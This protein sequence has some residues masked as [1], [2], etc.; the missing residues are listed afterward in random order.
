MPRAAEDRTGKRY[1]RWKV[2]RRDGSCSKPRGVSLW[3]CRCE[4]GTVRVLRSDSLKTSKSCGCLQREVARKGAKDLYLRRRKFPSPTKT[5]G[6][7]GTK[8]YR[9]WHQMIQRCHNPKNPTYER[10]GAIGI[11]VCQQWRDSFAAF[12]ADMGPCPSAK[13]TIDRRRSEG[14]YEPGNCRWLPANQQSR[15]RRHVKLY[16]VNGEK[17][18]VGEIAALCGLKV[19]T[20]R[21]RFLLGW[22]LERIMKTDPREYR[23][24]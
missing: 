18:T 16:D 13:H 24:S 20:V 8:E 2:L 10:Y 23:K 9:A 1:G 5:H 21:M 15:N 12:F 17:K 3:E 4:C 22:S 7:S 19:G 14:N 6:M 11:S